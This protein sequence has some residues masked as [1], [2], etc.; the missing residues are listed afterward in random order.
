MIA[1]KTRFA[2][3]TNQSIPRLE[4]LGALE[5]LGFSAD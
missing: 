1:T 3:L 2:P 4:L 5:L